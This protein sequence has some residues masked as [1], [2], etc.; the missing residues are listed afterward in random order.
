MKVDGI[1][2]PL[3]LDLQAIAFSLCFFS[4]A[5]LLL[6]H[7]FH[8]SIGM[9]AVIS[10][11]KAY[12]VYTCSIQMAGA[13]LVLRACYFYICGKSQIWC[14]SQIRFTQSTFSNGTWFCKAMEEPGQC[15]CTYLTA[16]ELLSLS[17]LLFF[18]LP[19]YSSKTLY[20]SRNIPDFVI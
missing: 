12:F 4:Y 7:S 1:C 6:E 16:N 11:Q 2:F 20:L 5:W 3:G 14:S 19:W 17:A 13:I 8:S 9:K 15:K 18:L 10:I